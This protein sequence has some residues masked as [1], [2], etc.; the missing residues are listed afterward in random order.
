M[1]NLAIFILITCLFSC[2]Y[3]DK[4]KVNSHDIVSEELETFNWNDVD[5]Y[6]SFKICESFSSKQDSKNCFDTTLINHITRQLSKE[7]IVVTEDVKDTVVMKFHISDQGDLSL[8]EIKNKPITIE[9]IPNLEVILT[10]SLDSLPKIF[11]AIKRGQQVKTEFTLPIV[12]Q[13]N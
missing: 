7:T 2:E 1:K 4:K 5:E 12:I 8:L 13:A 10:S 11:P 9:Q 3:Y 6:P